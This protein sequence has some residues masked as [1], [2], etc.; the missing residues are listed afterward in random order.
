MV[1]LI[2]GLILGLILDFIVYK[3][4]GEVMHLQPPL[5]MDVFDAPAHIFNISIIG[6]EEE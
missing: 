5:A 3:Y 1:M 6:L 2:L 4:E